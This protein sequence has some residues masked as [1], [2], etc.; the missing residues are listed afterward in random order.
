MG[1]LLSI[2]WV[3]GAWHVCMPSCFNYITKALVVMVCLRTCPAGTG[4]TDTAVQIMHVLYHNCPEQRTLLI[5]HS[6]QA[7]NDLFQKLL[8]RDVPA[9]YLLRLGMGEEELETALDFSRVG[10]VNAMLARRLELLA[11]VRTVVRCC[12]CRCYL[13][14]VSILA[15]PSPVSKLAN[16]QMYL[17]SILHA[18]DEA[19]CVF[20]GCISAVPLSRWQ[21]SS[22][23]LTLITLLSA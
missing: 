21:W 6:N 11:E 14:P 7:L 5:T 1:A 4:K 8:E 16:V 2:W 15:W 17:A 12:P 13:Y 18:V 9:R 3:C 10:R 20:G 23:I 22:L 19:P